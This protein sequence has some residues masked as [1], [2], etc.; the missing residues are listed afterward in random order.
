MNITN[1]DHIVLTVR[2][3]N[4]TVEFYES[5]LGMAVER[6]GEGRMALKFGDQKI[7]LHQ[8]GNEFKP[9][10]N[11]PTPGSQDICFLTTTKL[12]VAMEH[13]RRK[14]VNII[15]GPVT[16][17]GATG[18]IVSF[19]FRDPDGNLIEVANIKIT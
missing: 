11:Q 6:F 10:A 12:E 5:V 13:V 19:Y 8:L 4:N 9:R 1:I 14:G 18:A 3:I 2:D 15:E 17:M 16:R 7:G